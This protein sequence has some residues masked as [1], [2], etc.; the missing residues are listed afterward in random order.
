MKQEIKEYVC[1]YCGIKYIGTR[2][3]FS[4]HLHYCKMNPNIY[5]KPKRKSKKIEKHTYKFICKNCGKEYELQLTEREYLTGKHSYKNFC[6]KSCA[7]TRCHTSKT[8]QKIGNSVKNS[9][10]YKA[11]QLNRKKNSKNY[12][13]DE[14]KQEY[15][16]ICKKPYCGSYELNEKYPEISKRQSPKW[17]N[18]LIPFGLDISTLGTER[19]I[20]EYF[21][22]KKLLY[23]EYVVN[24]L[25]PKDIYLKYNCSTHINNS[26]TL[27]HVFKDWGFTTRSLSESNINARLQGKLQNAFHT[28]YNCDWHTTWDNKEVYLRSSYELEY[29][30]ELDSKQIKYE[31][32]SLRIKYFDTKE[33]TYRCAIPDFYLPDINTI[34]EIKSSWTYDEQNMKDKFKAYKELG[35]NT[36]LILDKVEYI[37]LENV[38]IIE[39]YKK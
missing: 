10:S 18:K 4:N 9:E 22:C 26:E 3:G 20:I 37:N 5:S 14:N 23:E 21:K 17:F 11:A 25:S 1:K 39:R 6:S 35:Y 36:K 7:N 30:Q 32:E 38:N 29:A 28:Q 27:L 31:V 15:I 34:V 33:N 13:Y 24:K 16:K 2:G 12:V 19:F 8:K